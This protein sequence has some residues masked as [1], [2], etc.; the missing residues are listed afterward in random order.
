MHSLNVPITF[1]QTVLSV[2][3]RH[4]PLT[5][6]AKLTQPVVSPQVNDATVV[7]ITWSRLIK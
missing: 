6:E 1:P 2:C 4:N 3:P 7:L 5:S